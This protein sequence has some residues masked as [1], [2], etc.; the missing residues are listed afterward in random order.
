MLHW[1]IDTFE[2]LILKNQH[3]LNIIYIFIYLYLFLW[4]ADSWNKSSF[5][6]FWWKYYSSIAINLRKISE[7]FEWSKKKENINES[8]A[9]Y[10]SLH[11]F[12]NLEEQPFF[13]LENLITK[14]YKH[15]KKW[16]L[17]HVSNLLTIKT[18]QSLSLLNFIVYFR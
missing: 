3:I 12:F 4:T 6:S 7:I 16:L 15:S 1:N 11:H 10:R 14:R 13:I 17:N 9:F 18:I 8:N 5:T 2:P